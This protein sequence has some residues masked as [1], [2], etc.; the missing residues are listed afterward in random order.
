MP[1]QSSTQTTKR[2]VIYIYIYIYIYIEILSN[3]VMPY[4]SL[5]YSIAS[6]IHS[7]SL[8]YRGYTPPPTLVKN[9]D[10][11][12]CC[13]WTVTSS[14]SS[15][16]SC[17]HHHHCCH[18]VYGSVLQP[19]QPPQSS[20][21]QQATSRFLPVCVP[22]PM[23]VVLH[24]KD[25]RVQFATTTCSTDESVVHGHSL[26]VTSFFYPHHDLHRNFRYAASNMHGT[27]SRTA[28]RN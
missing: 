4:D 20:T 24:T 7:L 10:G 26:P 16:S 5:V 9:D 1:H 8:P 21:T 2:G 15:S 17:L 23:Y 22:V 27:S 11:R 3:Q 13:D 6:T 12:W 25:M 28:A 14:S 18:L 19:P